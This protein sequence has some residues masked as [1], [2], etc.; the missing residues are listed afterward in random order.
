MLRLGVVAW[1]RCG[2]LGWRSRTLLFCPCCRAGCTTVLTE[3]TWPS[4]MAAAGLQLAE[5][6]ES[7][8]QSSLCILRVSRATAHNRLHAS[9]ICIGNLEFSDLRWYMLSS[10]ALSRE[11]LP[12][13]I[14]ATAR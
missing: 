4:H 6:P 11:L 5:V 7:L 9:S 1:L 2:A 13:D 10:T 8:C 14:P 12:L 3:E